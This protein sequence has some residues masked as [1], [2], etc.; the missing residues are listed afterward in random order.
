MKKVTFIL[1]YWMIYQFSIKIVYISS[2]PTVVGVLIGNCIKQELCSAGGLKIISSLFLGFCK[3]YRFL[4]VRNASGL[5][6]DNAKLLHMIIMIFIVTYHLDRIVIWVGVQL[7]KGLDY[8]L[9]AL[10][11][12]CMMTNLTQTWHGE[13][14]E[15]FLQRSK[16]QSLKVLVS[17]ILFSMVL[18]FFCL[19]ALVAR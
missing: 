1:E 5:V 18:T 17:Q 2:L 14:D 6:R 4:Y 7:W 8:E 11:K 15:D 16:S 19:G 12:F 9:L 3:L 10:G 13:M